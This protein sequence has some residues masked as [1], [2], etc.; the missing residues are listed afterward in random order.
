MTVVVAQVVMCVL[1]QGSAS[2]QGAPVL[3][4]AV[5]RQVDGTIGDRH[6]DP[7]VRV[8]AMFEATPIKDVL[9]E[10]GRSGG[11]IVR[12]DRAVP[13]QAKAISGQ[14]TGLSLDEALAKVVTANGMSFVVVGPKSVFVYSDTPANRE[15]FA[16]SV[17]MFTV[18]K[19]DGAVLL[20]Q[21]MA[22]IRTTWP[23]G[24]QPIATAV[25][26]PA[27]IFVRATADKMDEIA[28]FIASNDK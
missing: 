5:Q 19:A 22:H 7:A 18:A 6:L 15:K 13:E 24:I 28:K 10:I 14:L 2:L 16:V 3:D 21:L 26:A 27:M 4:P 17:R 8:S 25:R 12:F 11:L 9:A 1:L 23:D 20:G